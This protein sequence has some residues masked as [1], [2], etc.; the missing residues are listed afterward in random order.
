V[1]VLSSSEE[2]DDDDIQEVEILPNISPKPSYKPSSKP[3]PKPASKLAAAGNNKITLKIGS[4]CSMLSPQ[5]KNN[6]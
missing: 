5:I 3:S 1:E 4:A 6:F 2:D